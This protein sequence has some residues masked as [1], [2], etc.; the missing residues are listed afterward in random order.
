MFRNDVDEQ[1]LLLFNRLILEDESSGIYN[2]Q[3]CLNIFFT[4]KT[5]L[6]GDF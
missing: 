2:F 5:F 3:L 4:G 6:K 1:S